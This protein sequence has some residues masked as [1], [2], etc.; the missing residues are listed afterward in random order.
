VGWVWLDDLMPENPKVL[1]A[2]AAAAWLH[3]C[4][5]AYSNRNRTDGRIPKSVVPRLADVPKRTPGLLVDAGLWHDSGDEYEIHDYADY[6]LSQADRERR[7]EAGRKGARR[8]W[9]DGTSHSGSHST[10]DSESYSTPHANAMATPQPTPTT[11]TTDL[12]ADEGVPVR[13]RPAGDSFEDF[14]RP[15]AILPD[16]LRGAA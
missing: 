16:A 7:R 6:Q 10:P 2:G 3:V 5:I 15:G 12:P 13:G 9:G 1:R 11:T 8:R 4:G 14:K